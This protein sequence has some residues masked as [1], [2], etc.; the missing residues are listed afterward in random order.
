M[1]KTYTTLVKATLPS[2]LAFSASALCAGKRIEIHNDFMFT[3]QLLSEILKE[4][5]FLKMHYRC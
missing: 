1:E 4:V 3:F 5:K 2:A